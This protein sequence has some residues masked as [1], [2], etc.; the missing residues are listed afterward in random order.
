MARGEGPG[1]L[2]DTVAEAATVGAATLVA[3]TVA[4]ELELTCGAVYNPAFEI[5]PLLAFQVT[6][7]FEVL[8]TSAV[9]CWLLPDATLAVPGLTTTVTGDGLTSIS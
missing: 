9:N 5:V 4:D 2:I 6:L 8:L 3:V 1:A 7:V